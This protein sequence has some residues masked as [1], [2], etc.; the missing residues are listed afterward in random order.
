MTL[1][2]RTLAD[3]RFLAILLMGFSSGLPLLLVGGTLKYW[4]ADSGVDIKAIG[5][6]SLVAF[7]YA[8]KPLWAPVLDRVQLPRLGRRRGWGFAIQAGLAFALLGLSQSHPETYLGLTAALAVAVA[9]LSASQDVVI[10]ALRIEMLD[11]SEYALGGT[12]NGIGYRLAMLVA[13]AGA[14]YLA[15]GASWQTAYVSMAAL[16]AVGVAG[17]ALAAEP[18]G[19]PPPAASFG[20]W[21]REAVLD[22]FA[23]FATR[24]RWPWVLAF[25][26]LYKLGP[27]LALS[28]TGPFYKSLGFSKD[29]VASVTKLFGLIATFTGGFL[30]VWI[31]NRVGV[32]RCLWLGGIGQ[33]VALYPFAWLATSGHSLSVLMI[34]VTGE[35]I[36]GAIAATAFGTYLAGLCNKKFTATQ[37]ALLTA[38]AALSGDSLSGLMGVVEDHLGW[39]DFM[40]ITPLASLPGLWV[41]W[42]LRRVVVDC[43]IKRSYNN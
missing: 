4:L 29:E 39:R 11:P 43:G 24:K 37:F 3:R 13:G 38:L 2:L 16:V 5:W 17:L 21:W 34:S 12:L 9:F 35:N 33:I 10:D 14:L 40:L 20:I 6:F 23:E 1:N 18:L 42:Q 36:T 19:A 15:Q 28:L 8:A 30:G 31:I 26:V 41:L 25:V 32:W 22:P 7:P 27:V